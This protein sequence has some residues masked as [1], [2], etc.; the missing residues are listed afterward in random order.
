MKNIFLL[1]LAVMV[2]Q[3]CTKETRT[4]LDEV[5]SDMKRDIKAAARDVND[6]VQ[7]MQD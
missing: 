3:G 2:L 7:D 6:K 5:G 4:D 1:L